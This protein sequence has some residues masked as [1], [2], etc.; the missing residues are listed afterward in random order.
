MVPQI[1]VEAQAL[2]RGR[3]LLID[4][5]KVSCE[6]CLDDKAF[7]STM[8]RACEHAGANVISQI[9]YRFGHD[10]P[11]GF[12]ALCLLDESHI[13]AHT[14]ADA[15]LIAMD[16]FTCGETDPQLILQLIRE[17][18]D[19]GE[20]ECREESRFGQGDGAVISPIPRRTLAG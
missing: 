1:H 10:T 14:Y 6:V 7:L 16:I 2:S 13:T 12:T 18:V 17:E 8:A 15:G 5:R 9:R 4:C 19:L 11:A 3:H 20:V